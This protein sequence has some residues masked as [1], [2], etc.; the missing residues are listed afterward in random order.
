[1]SDHEGQQPPTPQ[2]SRQPRSNFR[3]RPKDPRA[4]ATPAPRPR[5]RARWN[6]I[7]LVVGFVGLLAVAV[8]LGNGGKGVSMSQVQLSPPPATVSATDNPGAYVP[9]AGDWTVGVEVLNSDCSGSSGCVATFRIAPKYVGTVPLPNVG[10][11]Q[12]AYTVQGAAEPFSGTVSVDAH[13][14][15]SPDVHQQV[16]TSSSSA[17]LTAVVAGVTFDKNR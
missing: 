1:M 6:M 16:R 13:G 11:T 10:A 15:P 5:K 4:V 14:T 7:G 8:L 9:S 3:P 2:P 12:L 17:K